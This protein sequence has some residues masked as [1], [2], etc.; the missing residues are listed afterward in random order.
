MRTLDFG[1]GPFANNTI[2]TVHHPTDSDIAFASVSF[3]GFVGAVTSFSEKLSQSEV[4]GPFH[5]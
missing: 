2:M 5:D 3:P 1:G 4:G